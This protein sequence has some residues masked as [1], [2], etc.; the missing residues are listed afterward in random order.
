[1]KFSQ[2]TQQKLGFYLS[3]GEEEFQRAVISGSPEQLMKALEL[4]TK[5]LKIFDD[6][7]NSVDV[8]EYLEFNFLCN[9]SGRIKSSFYDVEPSLEVLSQGLDLSLI[10][11]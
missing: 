2:Q 1:M 4:T 11:I 10:H 9:L 3:T 6:V 8:A 7:K 5:G